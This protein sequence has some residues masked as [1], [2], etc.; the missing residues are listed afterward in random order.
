MNVAEFVRES[1]KIEG[2]HREPTQNEIEALDAFLRLESVSVGDLQV[3]VSINQPGAILREHKHV[4][5][6]RVGSHVAPASGPAVRQSLEE[7]LAIV[8]QDLMHP[9]R[10]H[11]QYETLHP[12]TDGN[13]RSGRALWAWQMVRAGEPPVLGFLHTWYYQSL[14]HW[15]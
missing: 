10:V 8:R 5:N 12:F 11:S 15:D 13:G 4:V 2:I 1:N 7:L 3:F 14:Q 9:Y 6:V